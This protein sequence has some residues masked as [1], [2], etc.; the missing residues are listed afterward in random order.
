MPELQSLPLFPLSTIVLP[1]GLLPLRLFERRYLD[2]ISA[3]S[4]S[5][6]GFGFCLIRDGQEAFKPAEPY[7]LGTEVMIV[8][9]DQGKDGLLHIVAQGRQE[10]ELH[11]FTVG[12][13]GLL[14]GQIELLPR[15]TQQ[16]DEDFS[17]LAG[18]L[19]QILQ[20]ME[21]QVDYP[22][23]RLDDAEWVTNRLLELLPLDAEHK[24]ELL[25]LRTVDAR[26][27]ALLKL[28]FKIEEKD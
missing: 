2:M 28:P 8:D 22:D 20:F 16:T 4:K 17:D 19:G 1:E 6:T 13:S 25:Q 5:G 23:A 27:K 18:K 12:E 26:L 3:C 9:F 10:F 14:T 7:S 15:D 21:G 24:F 11:D